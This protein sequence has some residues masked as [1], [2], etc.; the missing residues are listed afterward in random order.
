MGGFSDEALDDNGCAVVKL[1]SLITY[2]NLFPNDFQKLYT[3]QGAAY[4][5]ISK[6]KDEREKKIG[7]I[8]TEL[9]KTDQSIVKL[10]QIKARSIGDE[11]NL[12]QFYAKKEEQKK[13]YKDIRNGRLYEL[14]D[15][16]IEKNIRGIIDAQLDTAQ[17]HV[18]ESC[19]KS[20]IYMLKEGLIDEDY[21]AYISKIYE[22][23]LISSDRRFLQSFDSRVELGLTYKL[24]NVEKITE[25][26]SEED[27]LSVSARNID[28]IRFALGN[29]K[30]DCR[31]ENFVEQIKQKNDF[32]FVGRYLDE[33]DNADDLIIRIA[34]QWDQFF[35]MS[36][37]I[38]LTDRH[39]M[40]IA[41]TL[42]IRGDEELVKSL[43]G[44]DYLKQYI[45]SKSSFLRIESVNED[46]FVKN[47]RI[48]DAKFIEINEP[49]SNA[50]LM[51]AV[52]DNNLYAFNEKNIRLFLNRYYD[53]TRMFHGPGIIGMVFSEEKQTL[54][55]YAKNNMN[56]LVQISVTGETEILDSEEVVLK[57]INDE[58]VEK[59]SKLDYLKKVKQRIS[60][61]RD[62][63]DDYCKDVAVENNTV[64]DT[65]ENI[66]HYY[67]LRGL[68][69]PLIAFI[70]ESESTFGFDDVEASSTNVDSFM[71]SIIK[72]DRIRESRWNDIIRNSKYKMERFDIG[73]LPPERIQLLIEEAIISP[74]PANFIYIRNNY[75]SMLHVFIVRNIA[76]YSRDNLG[77]SW[78]DVE[79]IEVL[80]YDDISVEDKQSVLR[81][82]QS[83]VTVI[84]KNYPLELIDAILSTNYNEGD[85]SYLWS[86]Y[87]AFDES[88]RSS[89]LDKAL[90]N[91]NRVVQTTGVDHL[92]LVDL[93]GNDKLKTGKEMIFDFVAKEANSEVLYKAL[94]AYGY[95][96]IA[97]LFSKK[98]VFRIGVNDSNKAVLDVLKR[99]GRIKDFA[100][101]EEKT[102]FDVTR[103]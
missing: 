20:L 52:Y 27:Y 17:K 64:D 33:V 88:A 34:E 99:Y 93:L 37:K 49:D 51:K 71:V 65:A 41:Q 3:Q 101:N 55:A 50:T 89:I 63:K 21:Y 47:M 35:E 53:K 97:A 102:F 8:R 57:V 11:S 98:R 45:E 92:L 15:D 79:A 95:P 44:N 68:N 54:C 32:E 80:S 38:G 40:K 96:D 86:H 2:K 12:K 81:S 87:S 1:F 76:S 29:P 4:M 48:I 91:T 84:D 28:L 94:C 46:Q 77:A 42:M 16:D 59:E 73:E 70:N 85:N 10:E 19:I 26:L 31:V 90:S 67:L 39:K 82:I 7:E 103:K 58:S 5:A 30:Y 14:F 18:N 24:E 75:R 100:E 60:R 62:I 74:T 66:L 69:D 36:V 13:E 25:D 43:N 6:L 61:I 9:D 22:N 83:S 23:D 78:R 72:E 56:L